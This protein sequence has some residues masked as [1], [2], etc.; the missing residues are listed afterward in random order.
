M[1]TPQGHGDDQENMRHQMAYIMV[2]AA[3]VQSRH[4]PVGVEQGWS[5]VSRACDV[6]PGPKTPAIIYAFL[7][8][9]GGAMT[10]PCGQHMRN[11]LDR[12]L[13]DLLPRVQNCEAY[14]RQLRWYIEQLL[15]ML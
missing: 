1:K 13:T 15:T 7:H 4:G 2:F 5:W 9:A 8:V 14:A 12:I 11:L 10:E 3:M 6:K